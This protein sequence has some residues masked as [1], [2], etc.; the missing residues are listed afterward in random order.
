VA[1]LAIK[2]VLFS[3]NFPGFQ[4]NLHDSAL[5]A[6]SQEGRLPFSFVTLLLLLLPLLQV[7]GGLVGQ[8]R[9]VDDKSDPVW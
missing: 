5:V 2:Q 3:G 6:C 1:C 7:N 9:A 8:T 4:H